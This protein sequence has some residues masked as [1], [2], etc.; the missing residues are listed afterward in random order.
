MVGSPKTA[1]V[2]GCSDHG[3]Y[4]NPVLGIF[5]QK[6]I[7]GCEMIDVDAEES[8]CPHSFG[9]RFRVNV[10]TLGRVIV[11]REGVTIIIPMLCCGVVYDFVKSFFIDP[12]NRFFFEV[13]NSFDEVGVHMCL[14]KLWLPYKDKKRF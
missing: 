10:T 14:E 8:F 3:E 6:D 12:F 11:H 1:H 7:I 9:Q 13:D 2:R 5:K 4:G